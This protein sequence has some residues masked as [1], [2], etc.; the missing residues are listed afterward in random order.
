MP[1]PIRLGLGPELLRPDLPQVS[2]VSVPW[3]FVMWLTQ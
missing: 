2:D 3:S 1:Y